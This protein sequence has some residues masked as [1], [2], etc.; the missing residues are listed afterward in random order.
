MPNTLKDILLGR[1]WAG[2]TI[3]RAETVER[4]NPL[5]EQHIRLNHEYAAVARAHSDATIVSTL[6]D[7]L[8]T[9]RGDVGKLS[10]TVL[11]CGGVAYNG[12]DLE[13]EDFD[14][15]ADE[16]AMLFRLLD[17]EEAFHDALE[18]EQNEVEHQI[19]TRSILGVV[20]TNSA[21]RLKTLRSWTRT[22]SRPA[23]A[24]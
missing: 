10:E 11:S 4:I 9:A 1:G 7:L 14:P 16:T 19:R 6:Q 22:L 8:K 24:A 20:Q 15:G 21:E 5:I 18:R 23:S 2:R 13:P 17:L 12:T 3:T